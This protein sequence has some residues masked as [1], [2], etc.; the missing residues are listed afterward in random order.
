ME[1][2]G[3]QIPPHGGIVIPLFI[4]SDLGSHEEQL[5]SRM[6]VHVR[7]ERPHVREALPFVAGHL[8]DQRLLAVHYFIV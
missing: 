2:E 5:F 8:A 3:Q 1:I 4:L 7:Q 6:R